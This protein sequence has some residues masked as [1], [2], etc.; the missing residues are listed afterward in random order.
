MLAHILWLALPLYFYGRL[1]SSDAYRTSLDV[2]RSSDEI[3]KLLGN[4]IHV[5]GFPVGSVLRQYGEDFAE[6]SVTLGGSAGSGRLYGVA[7]HI[8]PA[9]EF[10]RL[11]FVPE[12]GGSKINL[13]P[14]PARLNL[15]PGGPR[16]IYLVPAS[17]DADQSLGWAPAYY[18]A[19]FGA[20]VEI[21]PA[22]TLTDEEKDARRNQYAAEKCIQLITRSYPEQAGDPSNVLIAVTSKDLYISAFDWQYAENFRDDGRLAVVSDA[23]LHPTDYPGRWNQEL[24]SSRLQKMLTK[25][26]AILFAN[27]PLS[28][29][30]T[31][32]LSSGILAGKQIDYMSEELVG[33]EGR[34]DPSA[35]PEEPTVSIGTAPGKSPTWTI[36]G[37]WQALPNLRA[38]YFITDVSAGLFM[39]HQ[40]DFYLDEGDPLVFART[41]LPGI[42]WR[43]I[44]R[45]CLRRRHLAG[46]EER[47]MDVFLPLSPQGAARLGYRADGIYRPQGAQIRNGP[48]PIRGPVEHHDP[49]R[50]MASPRARRRAADS[51]R[52]GLERAHSPIRLQCERATGSCERFRREREVLYV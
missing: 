1:L 49:F 22:L 12:N 47:W 30:Y 17:L 34:W 19:K 35:L 27:L 9:W 10:S 23:R 4:G 31:S 51:S 29:D 40:A 7:N 6:W 42:E 14:K 33:A 43:H 13:T 28:D 36:G 24:L 2:A 38:E 46:Q 18:K 21:L 15:Q 37:G 11:V 5:K 3:Q 20:D 52:R 50:P 26:I 48:Q 39:Q 41:Y 45:R 25:N 8:G 44:Y 16:K 32:L